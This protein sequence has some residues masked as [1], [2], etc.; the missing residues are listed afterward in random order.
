MSS[1]HSGH[2]LHAAKKETYERRWQLPLAH[3]SL[4]NDLSRRM[5]AIEWDQAPLRKV[6]CIRQR[7]FDDAFIITSV[8]EEAARWAAYMAGVVPV[9][10]QFI[11]NQHQGQLSTLVLYRIRKSLEDFTAFLEAD[12][13]LDRRRQ[14][15]V[16][17]Y[18]LFEL[19]A[20]MLQAPFRP[21]NDSSDAISVQELAKTRAAKE[22]LVRALEAMYGFLA[23][24]LKGDS[25]KTE[26][27]AARHIP[28]FQTQI[29]CNLGME[30]MYAEL[31][32][33]NNDIIQEISDEEIGTFV[34]L[35]RQTKN[36]DYLDFFS[37][38]CSV[39]RVALG[40]KQ[41]KLA[42]LL[43]QEN[44]GLLYLLRLDSKLREVVVNTTGDPNHWVS[45]RQFSSQ[46][47]LQPAPREYRFLERQLR[48][49]GELCLQR[50]EDAIDIITKEKNYLTWEVSFFA[51]QDSQL[52][53]PLR[54]MFVD[55]MTNLFIDVDPNVDI[56]AEVKLAYAWDKLAS[57]PWASAAADKTQSITGSRMPF[58]EQLSEW[59]F[60]FVGLHTTLGAD[61]PD[62]NRLIA[63]V[64]TLLR[65]LVLFGYYASPDDIIQLMQPL[66]ELLSGRTDVPTLV[67]N[68]KAV[69][70]E[71][72][73]RTLMGRRQTSKLPPGEQKEVREW[74]ERGR[75]ER[76][77]NN[78]AMTE[79]KLAALEVIDVLFNFTLTVRVQAFVFDFKSMHEWNGDRRA[80]RASKNG[81]PLHPTELSDGPTLTAEQMRALQE[82]TRAKDQD[83]ALR[84][85]DVVREYMGELFDRGNYII[86]TWRPEK[87]S[88]RH[89][90][91]PQDFVE[92]LLDLAT[93]HSS[94]LCCRSLQLLN[95]LYSSTEDLLASAV[96]AQVWW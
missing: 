21:F 70:F 41:S 31:V 24:T 13:Q 83:E 64:L 19:V 3:P 80:T 45:L 48:L 56:F 2:W 49:F 54:A 76:S 95:R 42:K 23:Q 9:L 47:G 69:T 16:R 44:D 94:E 26:L 52:P 62:Q 20:A 14:K 1:S 11:R 35:L 43:M 84:F 37:V 25:R 90:N 7:Q 91:S 73:S 27:Y 36:P 88:D 46:G 18:G 22:G 58:F 39:D 38:L 79:V 77:A 53:Y 12:G 67:P 10:R 74:R 29:G 55:L 96:K 32:A 8:P 5:T 89:S 72:R 92:V 17:N 40:E 33:D 78:R 51:A 87:S 71:T 81:R 57:N 6:K 15:L 86:P 4:D 93:Y 75:L 85:V 28:F 34:S 50:C 66:I 59:I 63:A 68:K 65:N 60:E 61:E 82:I 30:K